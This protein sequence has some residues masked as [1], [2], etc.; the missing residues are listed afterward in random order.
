LSL[1]EDARLA[2][3]AGAPG[4]APGEQPPIIL[5]RLEVD[6]LRQLFYRAGEVLPVRSWV[7]RLGRTSL[8][9]RQELRQDGEAAIRLDAVCVVL[10]AA[11]GRPRPLT[12]A[13]RAYWAGWSADG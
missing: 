10:D 3:A 13:E 11:T 4:V 8:T 9:M 6:Y 1:L 12:D 2:W 5:A 7:L